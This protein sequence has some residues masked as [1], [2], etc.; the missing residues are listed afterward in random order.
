MSLVTRVLESVGSAPPSMSIQADHR[1][2]PCRCERACRSRIRTTRGPRSRDLY[3]RGRSLESGSRPRSSW[4]FGGAAVAQ[5][6]EDLLSDQLSFAVAVGRQD[7]AI[8]I[9]QR[10]RNRLELH[11]LGL[12]VRGPRRISVSTSVNP[13]TATLLF[14]IAI[15]ADE[16]FNVI[17][18]VS[19]FTPTAFI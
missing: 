10:A 3:D 14:G 8:A 9:L 17:A 12:L 13:S 19:I 4:S 2:S 5:V 7:D 6:L 16:G 1:S 18:P 11:R 15:F